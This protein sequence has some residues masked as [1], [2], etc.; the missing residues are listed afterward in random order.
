MFL[1]SRKDNEQTS[2]KR[3]S[4]ETHTKSKKATLPIKEAK[5]RRVEF[6]DKKDEQPVNDMT[7]SIE[8]FKDII[9]PSMSTD[10]SSEF[11]M[12]PNV[13][14]VFVN[15][16]SPTLVPADF[17]ATLI[18]ESMV[19]YKVSPERIRIAN[20]H[21]EESDA[22]FKG[23]TPKKLIEETKIIE[24]EG[25]EI[26][27]EKENVSP[28]SN[29]YS[30]KKLSVVVEDI[31]SPLEEEQKKEDKSVMQKKQSKEKQLS[32]A[33]SMIES[34]KSDKLEEKMEVTSD[35]VETE[36]NKLEKNIDKVKTYDKKVKRKGKLGN[37]KVETNI[38]ETDINNHK[39]KT[40]PVEKGS[41]IKKDN[42]KDNK[43]VKNVSSPERLSPCKNE[44][45]I[46]GK[47]SPT[48]KKLFDEFSNSEYD[49]ISPDHESL[50]QTYV[51][52]TPTSDIRERIVS[53]WTNYVSP[54]RDQSLFSNPSFSHSK[55]ANLQKRNLINTLPNK[56]ISQKPIEGELFSVSRKTLSESS[57]VRKSQSTQIHSKETLQK[58]GDKVLQKHNENYSQILHE[59]PLTIFDEKPSNINEI[60]NSIE[61]PDKKTSPKSDKTPLQ[62]NNENPTEV[63]DEKPNNRVPDEKLLSQNHKE[64]GI[65]NRNK[66]KSQSS[67]SED[68]VIPPTPPNKKTQSKFRTSL[69]RSKEKEADKE[70]ETS[71]EPTNPERL[72]NEVTMENKIS[73]KFSSPQVDKSKEQPPVELGHLKKEAREPDCDTDIVFNID[74]CKIHDDGDE[75]TIKQTIKSN[76]HND[77]KED[78]ICLGSS[79]GDTDLISQSGKKKYKQ[80]RSNEDL[81]NIGSSFGGT[82]FEA[83]CPTKASK[84]DDGIYFGSSI[85]DVREGEKKVEHPIK[86]DSFKD[87]IQL[88]NISSPERLPSPRRSFSPKLPLPM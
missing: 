17:E 8:K 37:K 21:T 82:D 61:I 30:Q 6:S 85:G 78:L 31:P 4:L 12:L 10:N 46:V 79:I 49:N 65:H 34:C 59:K 24:L 64:S 57:T 71:N 81:I 40:L 63:P 73:S 66:M 70:L 77:N 50:D 45:L 47:C 35:R 69:N 58:H 51:P 56:T 86:K 2:V 28:P 26:Y 25:A 14:R 44:T 52:R 33:E 88:K 27:L 11:T 15:N 36:K 20:S 54:N 29:C 80:R 62:I 5:K 43:Q 72:E 39:K 38:D 74:Y 1:F 53:L 68:C 7:S 42:F 18:D 60:F 16:I 75:E 87:D 32:S 41:P 3:K 76:R 19:D 83:T 48:P 9:Q 67:F 13:N 55:S 84:N 23:L 22:E